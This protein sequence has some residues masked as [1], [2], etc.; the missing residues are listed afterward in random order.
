VVQKQ[1]ESHT[2]ECS[3]GF[4]HYVAVTHADLLEEHTASIFRVT[5]L[6]W[7]GAE[8]AVIDI[9]CIFMDTSGSLA[10]HSYGGL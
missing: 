3:L 6:V 10:N 5:E 9:M 1:T 4:Q 7:V 2:N 8:G